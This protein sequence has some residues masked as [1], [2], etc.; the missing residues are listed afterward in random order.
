MS[1]IIK[2]GQ[3]QGED[4]A[5]RSAAFNFND[6]TGQADQYLDQVRHQAAA[7]IADAKQEAE[8]IR[9]R[10]QKQGRSLAMEAAGKLVRGEVDQ[11]LESVLPALKSAV[12]EVRAAKQAYLTQ[13]EKNAVHLAVAIASRVVRRELARQPDIPVEL[14][15]EALQ[16]AAGGG[17]MKLYLNPQDHK[18]LGDAVTQLATELADLAPADVLADPAISPGGCRVETRFGAIDQQFE[19]QLARIEEE[20]T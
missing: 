11:Q 1:V 20:L 4:H 3:R 8:Q 15:R 19:S 16:L 7:I 12:E 18:T 10:A 17:Q 14:I 5:V 6:M 2:A 13:W 9:G